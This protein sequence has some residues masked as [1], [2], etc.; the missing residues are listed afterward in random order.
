ME[1]RPRPSTYLAL[2]ISKASLTD[3]IEMLASKHVNVTVG[4]LWGDFNHGLDYVAKL[5]EARPRAFLS[6]GSVLFNDNWDSAVAGLQNWAALLR[7]EDVVLAG[8]DG[9]SLRDHRDKIWAAYHARAVDDL[10][11][12]FWANGFAHANRLLGEEWLRSED[13][14]P[15]AEMD[16][17]ESRHRFFFRAKRDVVLGSSGKVLP[18]GQE[19]DW[20]DS[21]KHDEE[22]VKRMCAQAGLVV[23]NTWEA[24]GSE[25][26][27]FCFVVLTLFPCPSWTPFRKPNC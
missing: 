20:F 18:A 16:D 21:H 19:M 10:F 22:V 8:M 24:P 23:V 5:S 9:H 4:G 2:D 17:K 1:K 26:R 6:L 15:R 27:K 7:P 12:R 14:E 11:A 13:W 25:M 3:N